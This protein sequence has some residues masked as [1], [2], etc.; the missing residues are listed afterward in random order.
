M[1]FAFVGFAHLCFRGRRGTDLASRRK[2]YLVHIRGFEDHSE[3]E[4]HLYALQTKSRF[5]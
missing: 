4:H 5:L 3:E 1:L 2:N